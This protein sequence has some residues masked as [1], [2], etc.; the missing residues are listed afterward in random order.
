MLKQ[1]RLRNFL[2]GMLALVMHG[3][4]ASAAGSKAVVASTAATAR[5]VYA[6]Y[7]PM[8]YKLAG[9]ACPP[10][11]RIAFTATE[12][13]RR[14]IGFVCS[15]GSERQLLTST[16]GSQSVSPTWA[17]DKVRLAFISTQSGVTGIYIYSLTCACIQGSVPLTLTANEPTWLPAG[18]QIAF[19]ASGGL[20]VVNIDGSALKRLTDMN[21]SAFNI[22]WSPDGT[23]IAYTAWQGGRRVIRVR[24]LG[25]SGFTQLPTP[26]SDYNPAWSPDGSHIAFASAQGNTIDLYVINVDGTGLQQVTNVAT[27]D[28]SPSWAADGQQLVFTAFA[29]GENSL[30]IINAD[31]TGLRPLTIEADEPVWGN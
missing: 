17:P 19:T 24:E 23:R 2:I 7:L 4:M 3:L 11:E 16:P 14:E 29:D 30:F 9:P 18:Q 22:A 25:G 5:G 26:G 1:Q 12:L 6:V 8:V 13:G 28:Y 21:E 10:A 27:A 15:D 20:Y 31:G